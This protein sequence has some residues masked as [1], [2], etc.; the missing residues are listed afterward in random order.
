MH[1]VDGISHGPELFE[2]LVV[3]AESYGTLTELFFQAFDKLDQGERV[4]VKVF[5]ERS[6][7]ADRRWLDLEDVGQEFPD[8]LEDLL[9]VERTLLDMGLRGHGISWLRIKSNGGTRRWAGQTLPEVARGAGHTPISRV[10]HTT[11]TR[12]QRI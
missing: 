5:G 1:V 3:D 12:K 6:R 9:A 4:S 11:E 8:E 10:V 2:V 7:L